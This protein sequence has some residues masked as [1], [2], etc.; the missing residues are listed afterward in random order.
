MAVNRMGGS[1]LNLGPAFQVPVRTGSVYGVTAGAV[2]QNAGPV[3]LPAGAFYLIPSGDYLI[4]PGLYTHLQVKDPITGLWFLITTFSGVPRQIHSDGSNYRLIN[5]SGC[6]VGAF[7]TNVGSGYTSAPTVTASAG[8]STWTAIVGGAINSTV[9]ITTAGV[10]YN[11][12]PILLVSAPPSGGVQASATCTI[13]G[14]V[15]NAVTV[16]NQGAGYTVAP[17]ITVLPDPR[18]VTATSPGPTTPGRLTAAL[19]GSGTITAVV[20]TDFGTALTAVP[21]FTFS[22]GG[23]ASAAATAVM[24]FVATGITATTAGA[25]GG[26]A[27]PFAVITTGGIVGGTAGAVVNPA[28]SNAIFHPRQANISGTTTSG[29]AITATGAVVNDGGLF[30]AIPNGI[31]I[32]GGTGLWTTQPLATIT[33]GGVS[34]TSFLYPI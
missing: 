34:N 11:Y 7:I 14:G 24:A 19:T 2:N 28:I 12:A 6:T 4:Q 20:P 3:S 32:T 22:G 8:S 21:T 9:T 29:G 16:I 33:V 25:G 31:A 30:Q 1:G 10:G 18:E 27:Q 5:I 17:T 23:G 15:I 26:N 13:S